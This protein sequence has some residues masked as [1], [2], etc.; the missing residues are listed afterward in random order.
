MTANKQVRAQG[1]TEI[2]SARLWAH[3]PPEPHDRIRPSR[4]PIPDGAL[5]GPGIRTA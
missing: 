3:T 1:E 2:R 5:A 4:T